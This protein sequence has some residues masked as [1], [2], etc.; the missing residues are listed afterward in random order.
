MISDK[1][2]IDPSAKVGANVTIGP[3]AIIGPNVE[4]GDNCSISSHAMIQGPTTIG[5]NNKFFQFT[6]IG[7]ECQI[8]NHNDD[9]TKLVIGDNNIFREGCTVHRGSEHGKRVTTIGHNNMF[10]VNSHIAHDCTVGDNVVFA[11]EASIAGH[12]VVGDYVTLSGK[13]GVHQFCHLGAYSFAAGGAIIFKDVMPYTIVAGNPAKVSGING[14]GLSRNNFTQETINRLQKAYKLI[15]RSTLT[16]KTVLKE[17]HKSADECE[18]VDIM[19][20]F[21]ETSTRGIVR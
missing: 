16:V 6:S 15:F 10:M 19:A 7:E 12:V 11:N 5:R 20:H 21:L 14:V 13:A 9:T 2:I 4:I 8:A 17:L 3:Y 1:A 18:Y